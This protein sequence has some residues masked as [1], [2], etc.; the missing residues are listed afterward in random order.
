MARDG[1]V[2]AESD[3]GGGGGISASALIW[4]PF[5]GLCCK[6]GFWAGPG[7]GLPWVMPIGE[8]TNIEALAQLPTSVWRQQRCS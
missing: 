1:G 4:P 6:V 7:A 8:R 2:Q 5:P 3:G